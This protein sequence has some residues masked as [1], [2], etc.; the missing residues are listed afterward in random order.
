[1]E[2][3]VTQAII[4]R[5]YATRRCHMVKLFNYMSKNGF[6]TRHCHRH[7]QYV[8]G[9]A[10]H[11][12]QTYQIAW[13]LNAENRKKNPTAL[14]LDE[15]S[16]AI[17]ALLH[18]LCDCSGLRDISGHGRRSTKILK[19][20]GFK[21]TQEEFL[22]I[23]FHMSLK[24]KESHPLYDDAKKCQLRYIVSKADSTSASVQ[25]GYKDPYIQQKYL[26]PSL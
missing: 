26:Y 24:G 13:R 11:S 6:F 21:L 15:D 7:H 23:R 12:W 9:L 10:D 19:E 25:K 16:I 1:M 17:A 22:A 8:S 20:I 18:D 14:L 2:F 5:L 3:N 4:D